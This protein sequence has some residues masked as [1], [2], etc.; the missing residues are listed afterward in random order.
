MSSAEKQIKRDVKTINVSIGK[1]T[2]LFLRDRAEKYNYMYGNSPSLSKLLDACA[3]GEVLLTKPGVDFPDITDKYE[4]NIKMLVRDYIGVLSM[5]AEIF[6]NHHIDIIGVE[7][8]SQPQDHNN[9]F[10]YCDIIAYVSKK[11]KEKKDDDLKIVLKE[12]KELTVAK[13][14]DKNFRKSQSEIDEKFRSDLRKESNDENLEEQILKKKEGEKLILWSRC[15]AAIKIVAPVRSGLFFDIT[16]KIAEQGFG[17]LATQ[18]Q[19]NASTN[20]I[21][22][23]QLNVEEINN[24]SE[25]IEEIKTYLGKEA[26]QN[27]GKVQVTQ[28]SIEEMILRL[29]RVNIIDSYMSL[30]GQQQNSDTEG[31]KNSNFPAGL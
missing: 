9:S 8:A 30:E 5:S 22:Y 24:F 15:S 25:L 16:N 1:N 6:K 23:F 2:E 13:L 29:Q 31:T 21:Y 11:Q 3:A 20:A 18:R 14:W 7:T 17:I 12:I 26:G 10:G 4:I 27:I 28:V 19:A